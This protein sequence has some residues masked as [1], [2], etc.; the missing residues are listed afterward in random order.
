MQLDNGQG[1]KLKSNIV[2]DG[3]TRRADRDEM[4]DIVTFSVLPIPIPHLLRGKT[5]RIFTYRNYGNYRSQRNLRLPPF[6][7]RKSFPPAPQ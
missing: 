5:E 6:C 2:F 4:S 1:Q 7:R 3:P